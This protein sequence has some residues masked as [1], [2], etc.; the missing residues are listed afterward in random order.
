MSCIVDWFRALSYCNKPNSRWDIKLT[1]CNRNCTTIADRCRVIN[2][3]RF[4]IVVAD[5]ELIVFR[6][7]SCGEV[8]VRV[9]LED[10]DDG[11]AIRLSDE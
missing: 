7:G 2:S 5:K 10:E 6:K 3:K 11:R 1:C 4:Q 9:P 8:V